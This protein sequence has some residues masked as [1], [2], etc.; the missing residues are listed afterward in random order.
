MIN[1]QKLDYYVHN[2]YLSLSDKLYEF[3]KYQCDRSDVLIEFTMILFLDLY[4][5]DF[6]LNDHSLKAE[7][8]SLFS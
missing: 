5:I 8:T 2:S 4:N 1:K 6:P 7:S 3:L